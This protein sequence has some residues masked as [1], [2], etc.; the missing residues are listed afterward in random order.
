MRF[1]PDV[2]QL[3]RLEVVSVR[4]PTGLL[5]VSSL[6]AADRVG[7]T[8]G[9]FLFAMHQHLP[10]DLWRFAESTIFADVPLLM[11]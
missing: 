2:T 10:L 7:P 3:S 8:K 11:L 5:R 9:L 6:K 1:L 4:K